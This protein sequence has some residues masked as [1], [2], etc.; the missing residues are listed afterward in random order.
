MTDTPKNR[1]IGSET[2]ILSQM[3]LENTEGQMPTGDEGLWHF[4]NEKARKLAEENAEL[5]AGIKRLS[6]EE[7]L[8]AETTGGDAFDLVA[9]AAKL[10]RTEADRADQWRLRREA[11]GSRDAARAAA[12]SL[13]MER[14]QLRKALEP[15][16]HFFKSE[17]HDLSVASDATIFAAF[18]DQA[19]GAPLADLSIADVRRAYAVLATTEGPDR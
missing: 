13:R 15:F 16:A 14:D 6:D 1:T 17:V 11:E 10:A 18:Q 5:R 3:T 19:T 4:W 9:L 12:D 8:Q 7:E 2:P